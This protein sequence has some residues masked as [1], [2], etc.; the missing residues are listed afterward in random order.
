M[1]QDMLDKNVIRH[2]SSSFCFRAKKSPDSCDKV[3]FCIDFRGLSS[4]AYGLLIVVT[5][6]VF[7][8]I[9]MVSTVTCDLYPQY[10]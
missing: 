6:R 9:S 4:V 1:M 7:V 8:Q 3:R 2:L 10:S 5:T